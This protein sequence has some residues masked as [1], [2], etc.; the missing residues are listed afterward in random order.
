VNEI[1]LS[2]FGLETVAEA[3][4]RKG[5]APKSVQNWVKA[6]LLPVVPVGSGRGTYLLRRSDVDAFTKPPRGRPKAKPDPAP[7]PAPKTR[8]RKKT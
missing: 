2:E 3:C 4:A 5:W 6:N 1:P 8:A 7:K